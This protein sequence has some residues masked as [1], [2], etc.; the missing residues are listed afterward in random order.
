[1]GHAPVLVGN[2]PD[3]RPPSRQTAG[4]LATQDAYAQ[5]KVGTR[6]VAHGVFLFEQRRYVAGQRL[7]LSRGTAQYH[8][9]DTRMTG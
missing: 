2:L 5:G 7:Q 9:G 8:A 1:M 6:L 3:A 4:P